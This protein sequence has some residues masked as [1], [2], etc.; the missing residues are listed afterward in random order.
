LTLSNQK[1][2]IRSP[3]HKYLIY[4]IEGQESMLDQKDKNQMR[5]IVKKLEKNIKTLKLILKILN[6]SNRKLD[7]LIR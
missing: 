4:L 3:W 7:V 6:K 5:D 2:N 1:H